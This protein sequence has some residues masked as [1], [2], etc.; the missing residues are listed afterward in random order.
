MP[1][2]MDS[3]NGSSDNVMHTLIESR[4]KKEQ[5]VCDSQFSAPGHGK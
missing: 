4:H 3:K 1:L 2:G 5:L